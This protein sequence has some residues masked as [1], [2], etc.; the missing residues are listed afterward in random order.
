MLPF[1]RVIISPLD[2]SEVWAFL[3]E[4]TVQVWLLYDHPN[5]KYSTL[6]VSRTEKQMDGQTIWLLDAPADLS[7]GGIKI[8]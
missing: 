1:T 7:S 3:N 6:Y 5:F 2:V 4:L 8:Q